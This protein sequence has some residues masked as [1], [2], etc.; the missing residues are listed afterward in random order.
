V[1][2]GRHCPFTVHP[3]RELGKHFLLKGVLGSKLSTSTARAN[4]DPL[5][6]SVYELWIKKILSTQVDFGENCQHRRLPRGARARQFRATTAES[7][8][9]IREKSADL[10]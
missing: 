6:R 1:V 9:P 2:Q 10:L 5:V 3:K 8:F 4:Y 7:L